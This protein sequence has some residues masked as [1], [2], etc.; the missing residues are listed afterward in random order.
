LIFLVLIHLNLFYPELDEVTEDDNEVQDPLNMFDPKDRLAGKEPMVA[1]LMHQGLVTL[2]SMVAP[3]PPRVK[4]GKAPI[5]SDSLLMSKCVH[6]L[7][8]RFQ[9]LT[10]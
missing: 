7:N 6:A 5:I 8:K 2:P 1:S 10:L 4:R 3:S 9:E